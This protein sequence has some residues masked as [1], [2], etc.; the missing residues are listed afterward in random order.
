MQAHA[1]I[2][3]CLAV[4]LCLS[5]C[6]HIQLARSPLPV[7]LVDG[8]I[9]TI[10]RQ[11]DGRTIAEKPSVSTALPQ[12]NRPVSPITLPEVR[13]GVFLLEDWF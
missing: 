9:T 12:K 13:G 2:F 6:Q 4:L 7:K 10:E 5:G 8:Q 11:T 1:R 3:V